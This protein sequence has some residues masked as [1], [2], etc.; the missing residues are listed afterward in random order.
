MRSLRTR[1]A[2]ARAE[3]QNITVG[4][5]EV[6]PDRE[7]ALKIATDAA[8]QSGYALWLYSAGTKELAQE[9]GASGLESE[10]LG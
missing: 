3:C 8:K 2:S 1:R 4:D 10:G 5:L 9:L 7:A 6:F